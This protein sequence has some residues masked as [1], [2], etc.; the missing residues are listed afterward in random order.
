MVLQP[1]ETMTASCLRLID[2]RS[3]K[4]IL[5]ACWDSLALH[6]HSTNSEDGS[7]HLHSWT[8]RVALAEDNQWHL[9][10]EYPSRGRGVVTDETDLVI[11]KNVTLPGPIS[12]HT[13]LGR[14]AAPSP[15]SR[16]PI[17]RPPLSCRRDVGSSSFFVEGFDRGSDPYGEDP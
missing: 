3:V 6:H 2:L 10:I 15:R 11:V 4:P 7:Q 12:R 1:R 9:N 16:T 14:L 8:H 5:E 13:V 17:P